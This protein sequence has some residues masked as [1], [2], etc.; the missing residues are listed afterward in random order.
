MHPREDSCQ[1]PG[2]KCEGLLHSVLDGS[3]LCHSRPLG[4]VWNPQIWHRWLTNQLLL[5]LQKG[6][7]QRWEATCPSS[8]SK[9]VVI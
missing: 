4:G 9:L 1:L 7:A 2:L 8:H 3:M 6:Q 5:S